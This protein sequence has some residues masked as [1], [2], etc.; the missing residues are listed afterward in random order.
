MSGRPGGTTQA[1]PADERIQAIID[2][3]RPAYLERTGHN[4]TA[5]E[6]K[7]VATQVVAGINYFVKVHVGEGRHAHLRIYENLRGETSLTN[8]QTNK[9]AEEP[10]TYF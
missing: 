7:E 1:R 3:V 8:V 6:A 10:L 2:R 9:G 4:P 5:W